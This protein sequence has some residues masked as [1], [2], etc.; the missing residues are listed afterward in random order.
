M[1][2]P[3]TGATYYLNKRTG[4]IQKAKPK[5]VKEE[6]GEEHLEQDDRR[7]DRRL[8]GLGLVSRRPRAML[9]AGC[10]VLAVLGAF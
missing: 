8:R 3:K 2:E 4:Q 7:E 5:N 9:H 6:R 1:K 10:A